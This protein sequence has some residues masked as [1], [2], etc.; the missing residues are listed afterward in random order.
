MMSNEHKNANDVNTDKMNDRKAYERVFHVKDG[1][2]YFS[3][4]SKR[5]K[6]FLENIH[7]DVFM[8]MEKKNDKGKQSLKDV[9][10]LCD[11]FLLEFNNDELKAARY[12]LSVT[13]AN[14]PSKE[15]AISHLTYL[16]DPEK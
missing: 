1:K 11:V 12:I 3:S 8:A 13:K 16:L 15:L 10:F 6:T 7:N 2:G 4:I 14:Y 5:V 9:N